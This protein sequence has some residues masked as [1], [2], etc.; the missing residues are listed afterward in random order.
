M[1]PAAANRFFGTI[2]FDYNSRPDG[3]DRLREFFDV[4]SGLQL[5]IG[6][7]WAAVAGTIGTWV[8]LRFGTWMKGIQR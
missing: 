6:L 5:Y 1:T 3:Y 2:Y 7:A 8:G 4:A